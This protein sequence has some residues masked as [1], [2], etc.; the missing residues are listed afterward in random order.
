MLNKEKE[1]QL[2][3]I[4]FAPTIQITPHYIKYISLTSLM[5][6]THC[7]QYIAGKFA[8]KKMKR[9]RRRTKTYR[10]GKNLMNENFFTRIE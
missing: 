3:S 2:I 5:K 9:T 10:Q 7:L 6:Q 1:K 4:S 8:N